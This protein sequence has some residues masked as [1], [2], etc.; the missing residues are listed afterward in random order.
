VSR[1]FRA[2]SGDD[3]RKQ[4]AQLVRE[5][6]YLPLA[7]QLGAQCLA[8]GHDVAS[9][10]STLRKRAIDLKPHSLTGTVS[11]EENARRII[12]AVRE[13]LRERT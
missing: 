11:P 6:G 13:M 1:S 7:I 10:L 3:E 4:F 8:S 12:A 9:F 2:P 5:L